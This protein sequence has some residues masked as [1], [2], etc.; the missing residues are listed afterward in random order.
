MIVHK[1]LLPTDDVDRLYISIQGGRGLSSSE[2]S[3]D[4]SIYGLKDNIEK[5]GNGLITAIRNNTYNTKT[6]RKK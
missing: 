6:N 2:Y 5:R 4:A 1:A 3:V